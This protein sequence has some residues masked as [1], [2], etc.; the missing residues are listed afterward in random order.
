MS[1]ELASADIQSMTFDIWSVDIE[2]QVVMEN[3]EMPMYLLE[4]ATHQ[5]KLAPLAV[6]VCAINKQVRFLV[7]ISNGGMTDIDSPFNVM[8]NLLI[9]TTEYTMN[10]EIPNPVQSCL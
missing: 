5:V 7:E 1:P 6:K 10:L 9:D 4:K 3:L 8:F 2:A